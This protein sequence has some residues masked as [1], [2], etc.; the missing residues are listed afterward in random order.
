[1]YKT[2]LKNF[3]SALQIF[4]LFASESNFLTFKPGFFILQSITL[5]ILK[6]T[7]NK[8]DNRLD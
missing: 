8:Y 2:L 6:L 5:F 4:K 7:S 3:F 1:M